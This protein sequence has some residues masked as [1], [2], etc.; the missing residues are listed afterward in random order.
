M[1]I[2]YRFAIVAKGQVQPIFSA[3][4]TIYFILSRMQFKK[5]I[6]SFFARDI[7][8]NFADITVGITRLFG[9]LKLILDRET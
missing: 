9:P 5:R 4:I 6:E 2:E 8:G 7:L 1:K 3:K